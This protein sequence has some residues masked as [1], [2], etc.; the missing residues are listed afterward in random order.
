[1]N[2]LKEASGQEIIVTVITAFGHLDENVVNMHCPT[3]TQG[4][5]VHMLHYE[6]ISIR[7]KKKL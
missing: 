2:T 1:M 7:L 5:H 4:G 3:A 6:P